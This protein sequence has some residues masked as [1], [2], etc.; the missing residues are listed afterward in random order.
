MADNIKE[1]K[2]LRNKGQEKARKFIEQYGNGQEQENP[3]QFQ[4]TTF[5]F[6]RS[7]DGDIGSRSPG[8]TDPGG[9]VF[10]LSPDIELFDR[11]GIS[12]ERL[13]EGE[14]YRVEVTLRNSGDLNAYS[15]TVELYLCDPALGFSIDAPGTTLIGIQLAEVMSES[16]TTV[17]FPFEARPPNIGHK[18]M[19]ARVHSVIYREVPAVQTTLDPFHNRHDAQQNLFIVERGERIAFSMSSFSINNKATLIIMPVTKVPKVLLAYQEKIGVK[20]STDSQ[21]LNLAA[22]Q[23][24]I[25][26]LPNKAAVVPTRFNVPKI[27]TFRN[28]SY[29]RGFENRSANLLLK[30]SGKLSWD[31]HFKKTGT[32]MASLMVPE[33]KLPPKE[34]GIFHLSLTDKSQNTVGG[35]TII[36]K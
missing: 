16:T 12:M 10:W 20:F 27:P 8:I 7:F 11:N 9:G 14:S 19:F 36:V 1:I 3:K 6:I 21:L 18:C 32:K 2:M 24:T 35:I 17:A 33:F 29:K 30:R 22:S 34:A 28:I 4:D 13:Q 31:I 15:C 25:L 23:V 26:P 5:L